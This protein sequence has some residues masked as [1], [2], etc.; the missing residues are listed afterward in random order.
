MQ[1]A[2][3]L[4]LAKF[5]LKT[6]LL[7]S[8]VLNDC[9][10]EQED[11]KPRGQAPS[12][13]QILVRR[14]LVTAES[15]VP[16]NQAIEATSFDCPRCRVRHAFKAIATSSLACPRCA[17]P[18]TILREDGEMISERILTGRRSGASGPP[19][20][21]ADSSSRFSK[22]KKVS[23][24]GPLKTFGPYEILAELGR[25]GM[26]VVYKA[27][28]PQ[29]DQIVALKVLLAGD[30]ASKTQVK[31]FQKE[32]E[33][34]GKLKH[35]GIVAI[36]D[37]GT[38]DD[39]HY[40]TMDF[41]EGVAL[42]DRVK[43][44]DLP[45]RQ[46]VQVARD[47]ARALGHAHQNGVIHR[48][49]KPANIILD[50]EGRPHLTDFGLAREADVLDSARLTREGATVGTPF[51]MSPEQARGDLAAVGPSTDIYA[52]G[53]VLFE[54]LTF[55]HPF[56]AT[57]QVELTRRILTEPP[58]RLTELE[59]A[60][61]AEVEAIVLKALEKD[62]QDRF[63]TADAFADELDRYLRGEVILTRTAR[64]KERAR[65]AVLLLCALVGAL[66]VGL[67]VWGCVLLYRRHLEQVAIDQKKALDELAAKNREK[68]AQL[69]KD[70]EAAFGEADRLP[71]L[72]AGEAFHQ[73]LRTAVTFA[74]DGLKLDP[75][76]ARGLLVRGRAEEVLNQGDK[77][78][79]DYA[80]A[81]GADPSGS[82]GV[83]AGFREIML[84]ERRGGANTEAKAAERF[85]KLA[86]G[87]GAPVWRT[88]ARALKLLF[89]HAPLD[90]V[91][92]EIEAAKRLDRSCPEVYHVAAAAYME[93][94]RG[95]HVKDV[96]EALDSYL[97]VER[98]SARAYALRARARFQTNQSEQADDDLRHALA[99]DPDE[100]LALIAQAEVESAKGNYAKAADQIRR[101]VA[102][103]EGHED[104][105]IL[106]AAIRI[107]GQARDLPSAQQAAARAAVLA[108]D[109]AESYLALSRVTQALE[110]ASAT[111]PLRDGLQHCRSGAAHAALASA[112]SHL[113][114][115]Q[116]DF[117]SAISFARADLEEAPADDEREQR[118]AILYLTRNQGN[119]AEVGMRLVDEILA[120]SPANVDAWRARFKV[121]LDRGNLAAV[122][123]AIEA[124][125]RAAPQEP[126]AWIE[127][128]R[129]HEVTR[130]L[131]EALATA[132]KA[133]ALDSQSSVANAELAQV[134]YSLESYQDAVLHARAALD[135]DPAN[136]VA[137]TILGAISLR[138]KGPGKE[139]YDYLT[140][141]LDADP[142]NGDAAFFLADM[143]Y[144]DQKV[145]GAIKV[146]H[147]FLRRPGTGDDR[148][149]QLL[150]ICE[151][152]AGELGQAETAL[153]RSIALNGT[154]A[155]THAALGEVLLRSGRTSD[156]R[157]EVDLALRLDPQCT[158][159]LRL[160][161]RLAKE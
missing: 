13:L 97:E 73:K 141:A 150:G 62:P 80:K 35:P 46:A 44:R 37:V 17:A 100:P 112:Y 108:P 31:R 79:Q 131:K 82:A 42:N 86:E 20:T 70:A 90:T 140:A 63:V 75:E 10:R 3:D 61:D 102:A 57:G 41:I 38:I 8:E 160:R 133:V 135:R 124:L 122:D 65:H 107:Y 24:D 136:A 81:H 144:E 49:V 54:M 98:K 132:R 34:A 36:H 68:A 154:S 15:L 21:R 123:D 149:W 69:F 1:S 25:G 59:P 71:P 115:A 138:Q 139:A 120:R 39:R 56:K 94:S 40:F 9:L 53:V 55:E 89:D 151:L 87:S 58:P 77:A 111:Q 52:L 7:S 134:E 96:I 78:L 146:L 161:S 126:L 45:L 74:T 16:I 159:A 128:T 119:D 84:S 114:V 64:S 106:V 153:R 118:L 104:V 145:E 130:R 125:K 85:G 11:Q 101:V 116:G 99:L 19:S 83:E 60:I 127:I 93:D 157:S 33:L 105:N 129:V 95:D 76:S 26:G 109:A 18:L 156:A 30:M 14:R 117:E 103:Q 66:G 27:R 67:A 32:A 88:L 50:A 51:Y 137:L 47:L 158:P 113:L 148:H 22:E 29:L 5:A 4:L 152:A 142:T 110:P 28:H 48:D 143:L 23:G 2:Q 72:T 155:E 12:L 121:L 43:A 92:A 6:G 91:L 147:S